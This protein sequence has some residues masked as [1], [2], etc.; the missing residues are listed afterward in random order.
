MFFHFSWVEYDYH[1]WSSAA[2]LDLKDEHHNLEIA[3]CELESR[4]VSENF[5]VAPNWS[6]AA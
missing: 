2:T 1:G 5:V 6:C 3:D 4:P